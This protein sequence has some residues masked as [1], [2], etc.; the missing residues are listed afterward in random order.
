MD[1]EHLWMVLVVV[2]LGLSNTEN[3][4]VGNPKHISEL[5]SA[6]ARNVFLVSKSTSSET[7]RPGKVDYVLRVR[8]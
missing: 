2:Q 7:M 4:C 3:K 6:C 5:N 1:L 8:I